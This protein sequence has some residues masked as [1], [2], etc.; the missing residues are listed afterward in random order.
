MS[1]ILQYWKG[2]TFI[3]TFME[4]NISKEI[5]ICFEIN[6][7]EKKSGPWRE[8]YKIIACIRKQKS[9]ISSLSFPLT[10][11]DQKKQFNLKGS[12]IKDKI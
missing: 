10:L 7:S 12:W 3:I 4:E 9:R 5:N 2:N 1:K 8:M 6:D 11:L